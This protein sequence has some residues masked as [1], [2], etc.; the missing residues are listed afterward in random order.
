VRSRTL[1]STIR[2]AYE[3]PEV[4]ESFEIGAHRFE[5]PELS[6]RRIEIVRIARA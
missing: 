1:R 4:G 6:D 2:P 5:V 3:L